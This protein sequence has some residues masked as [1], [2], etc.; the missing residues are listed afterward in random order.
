MTSLLGGG[1]SVQQ[2]L[3][4]WLDDVLEGLIRQQLEHCA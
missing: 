2:T 3:Q 4:A 1:K